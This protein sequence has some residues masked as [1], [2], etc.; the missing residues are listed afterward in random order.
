MFAFAGFVSG[1]A[2]LAGLH[3]HG[4]AFARHTTSMSRI[5]DL[6][7]AYDVDAG[8]QRGDDHHSY[9]YLGITNRDAPAMIVDGRPEKTSLALGA[10]P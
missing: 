7:R 1:V 2:V 9:G 10:L 6:T 4:M 8:S 3:W 5:Q